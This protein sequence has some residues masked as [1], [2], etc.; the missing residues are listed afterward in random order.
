MKYMCPVCGYPDL[1]EKPANHEICPSCGTQFGYDDYLRSHTA[2][3]QQWLDNDAKWF[4]VGVEPFG[5]NPYR[6]MRNAGFFEIQDSIKTSNSVANFYYQPK[7]F[8]IVEEIKDS[9][10]TTDLFV[11]GRR[12]NGLGCSV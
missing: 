9:R 1:D 7:A 3:R 12:A 5:W 4:L 6:Q 2:L 10:F 11:I 8:E